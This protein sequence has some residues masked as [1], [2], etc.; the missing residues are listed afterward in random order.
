[1]REFLH[2]TLPFWEDLNEEQKELSVRYAISSKFERG[3]TVFNPL[4]KMAGLK[5]AR[6]GQMKISLPYGSAGD[7][8]LYLVGE[9]EVCVLSI[10]SVMKQFDWA[11]CAVAVEEAEVVTIPESIYMKISTENPKVMEY[12]RKILIMRMGEIIQ[13]TSESAVSGVPERLADLLLRYQ[14]DGGKRKLYLT[15]EELAKDMG[16]ARE[17]VSRTLRQFK[18]Q[19]AIETGRGWIMIRNPEYLTEVKRGKYSPE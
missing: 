2:R 4:K 7:I 19:E 1:M 10:M 14:K 3:E 6:R 18:E 13:V 5:I 9:G 8:M 11:V 12:N 16:T 15:H 17:V